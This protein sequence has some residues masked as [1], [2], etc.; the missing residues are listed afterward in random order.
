MSSNKKPVALA[1]STAL[2]LSGSAF[3]STQLSQGYQL[4]AD[5]VI[6][7][8]GAEGSCGGAK[9]GEAKCGANKPTAEASCGA[10]KPAA[11]ASCGANK[12]AEGKCGGSKPAEG[13]CGEGSCGMAKMDTDKDGKLSRAEFAA[14]HGGKDDKFASHDTNKDGFISADEMK[15]AHEGKCGEG[16]CGGD[17]AQ[18]EG[19]CGE[20][21]CGGMV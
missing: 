17:K 18:T 6:D 3:A 4:G 11:E 2:L 21:K 13:K 7:A 5:T 12:P 14:A 1:I 15:A 8:K 10:N 16:K 19:K 9:A 20:G